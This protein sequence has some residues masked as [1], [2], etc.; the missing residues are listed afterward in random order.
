MS[1]NT[2]HP[3][4]YGSIP[5]LPGSRTGPADRHVPLGLARRMTE[6]TASKHERVV[7]QEKLD[8]SCV[9]AL[10]VGGAVVALGRDGSLAAGSAFLGRRVFA[11]WVAQ[12]AG[13]FLDVLADGER[14][15]GEWLAVAHGTRYALPHEPF[16]AFD[17]M[18]GAE[19][20][21]YAS[22]QARVARAGFVTP[23]TL[24]VG[25]AVSVSEALEKLGQGGHGAQDEVEGLVWRLESQGQ[26]KALAKFVRAGKQDGALL[27]EH[28]G[29]GLVWN[30]KPEEVGHGDIT[31]VGA[32]AHLD[33]G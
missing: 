27:P 22:L 8:G 24:S 25:G 32:A 9:A 26:V 2:A 15:V 13:R 20:L 21:T 23:H 31:A 1:S 12:E 18:R 16:V 3:K 7:V 29:Q 19:R 33:H 17:L 6:R 4:A 10:R 14:L 11:A 28:T 5:H 30:W